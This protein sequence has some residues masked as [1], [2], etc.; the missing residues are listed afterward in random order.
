[1]DDVDGSAG[2]ERY[3]ARQPILDVRGNLH[4]YE[5]LFRAGP[6][7]AFSGDGD[8]AT[9]DV[10]DN[11]MAGG[12]E[13]L[14]GEAVMFV[15]CTEEAL[16]KRLVMVLPPE[17][18]VL[19]LLETLS[20][21][22]EL[23]QACRELKAAGYRLALDDF[24]W[25]AKW[26]PFLGLADYVKVDLSVT[27]SA[28]RAALIKK[29]HGST[30]LLVAERVETR[31]D[32]EMARREGFTLFQGYYFCRPVL[33]K[34]RRIPP[35]QRVQLEMI[36]ALQW[37]PLDIFM[38]SRMVEKDAALTYRLLRMVNS[39]IYAVRH[40]VNSIEGALLMVGD[41]MFRRIATVAIVGKWKEQQPSELLFATFVRAKFCELFAGRVGLDAKEQYLLGMMSLL[42]ALISVPMETIVQAVALRPEMR[43]ALL[44]ESNDESRPL[45]V[46]MCY[47]A[48]KWETCERLAES[49]GA[50]RRQL[51]LL[52]ESALAWARQNVELL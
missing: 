40:A 28:S 49:M 1:M 21:S 51:P 12:M 7:S 3:V 43:D 36:E 34:S 13:R 27:T 25:D 52:Y 14:A 39:P 44:G 9:R 10:L 8:A 32:V 48:G 37:R 5:L 30:A 4:G 18:T 17:R 6:V 29:L 42:P 45:E 11:L 20:P 50:E 15:N 19:E 26:E 47:E 31:G 41:D 22:E 33:M 38:I 23:L 24:V 46:L 16:C 35:N 2:I